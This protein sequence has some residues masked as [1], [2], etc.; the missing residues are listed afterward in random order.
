MEPLSSDDPA[1]IGGYQLRSRLGAGG[2][3]RVYLA[4]TPGGRRVALKVVRPELGDDPD[5]R[6]RF[7]QEIA[8]ARR[9]RGVYTAELLNAD[10]EATP[11]WLVTA[12]VPGPSLQRAVND[13]GPLPAETVILLVAGVA[14]ALQAIH[15]AGVV[16]RDLKPSNVMLAPDGPRVIDFGIARAAE[17]ASV[18]RSGI[19]VGSPQFM[20]PEQIRGTAATP[21]VDV[22]ALGSVAAFSLLGR[23]PFGEGNPAALMHRVLNEPPDLTGA[24]GPLRDLIQRCLAKDPAARPDPT[25][26]IEACRTLAEG[27]LGDFS[28][29][30]W[31]TLAA[32]AQTGAMAEP[33]AAPSPAPSG[34]SPSSPAPGGPAR[35]PRP[36]AAGGLAGAAAAG[37]PGSVDP[38]GAPAAGAPVAG[39]AASGA[40]AD[41]GIVPPEWARPRPAQARPSAPRRAPAPGAPVV[42]GS[43]TPSASPAS[44]TPTSSR[45]SHTAS[46]P[47]TATGPRTSTGSTTPAGSRSPGVP[48]GARP[49]PGPTSPRGRN[50]APTGPR[51]YPSPGRLPIPP[52]LN[53]AAKFMYGGAGLAVVGLLAGLGTLHSL[54]TTIEQQNPSASHA[55]VDSTLGTAIFSL[56]VLGGAG[57]MLWL[58]MARLARR[59]ERRARTLSTVLFVLATLAVI[60]LSSRGEATPLSGVFGLL[61]WVTGLITIIL[62]WSVPSRRYFDALRPP[63]PAISSRSPSLRERA[64]HQRTH[65]SEHDWPAPRR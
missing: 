21:A 47:R 48:T 25:E 23:V 52:T 18:T 57:A 62:L 16:H 15:A 61:E 36:A 22:F 11:P 60:N 2:M 45:P 64:E 46:N 28:E 13:H 59:G 37:S 55:Y 33:G 63:D 4:S 8:A 35:P 27:N 65:S 5:F 32:P 3:G 7:R 9:V 49:A 29:S 1:E 14:E 58:W 44:G 54:R 6:T 39:S 40:P 38:A 51:S 34:G 53:S 50:G 19:R 43:R 10:P 26:I 12:Y 20:A 56:V 30:A 17:A 42:P 31:P 24:R 41:P